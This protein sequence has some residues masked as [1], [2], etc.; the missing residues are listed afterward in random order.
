VAEREVACDHLA[1]ELM[2]RVEKQNDLSGA[3]TEAMSHATVR[4]QNGGVARMTRA[5]PAGLG[6][7]S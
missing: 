3:V 5:C 6:D 4:D 1:H 2:H 7:A